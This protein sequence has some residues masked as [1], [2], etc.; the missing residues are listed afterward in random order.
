MPL[1]VDKTVATPALLN[2]IAQGADIVIHSLTKH[3]NE[4]GTALGRVIIDA[5]KF[6]WRTENFLNSPNLPSVTTA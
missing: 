5:G 1:I 3:I 6:N 4:N 2:P